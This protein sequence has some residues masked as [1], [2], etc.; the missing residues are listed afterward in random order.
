MNLDNFLVTVGIR[1]DPNAPL[2][3]LGLDLSRMRMTPY[4]HQ[5][6][7]VRAL[8]D[9]PWMAL[10]DEMGAGKTKQTLDAAQ[11]LWAAGVIDRVIIVTDA[12]VRDVWYDPE[13]GEIAKH[14]WKDLKANI[15][16]YHAKIRKWK[17]DTVGEPLDIPELKIV[18]A[19]YEFIRDKVRRQRLL[20]FC[21]KRTLLVL[22]ESSAI[23]TPSAKQTKVCFMLRRRCGRIVLLNGTPVADNPGDLYTQAQILHNS[24]LDCPTRQHFE[25]R[26]AKKGIKKGVPYPVIVDWVNLEDLQQRLAP[27]VLRR[28]KKD[29]LDLPEKMPPVE[30]EVTLRE[31]WPVYKEM[32]DQMVAWLK[33]PTKVATSTVAAVKV[34]RL[35]QIAN[36]FV[37]GVQTLEEDNDATNA[38]PIPA[39]IPRLFD[40]EPDL[41]TLPPLGHSEWAY[42]GS[43]K[44]DF[45]VVKLREWMAI[46]PDLKI[47]VYCRFKVE[48]KRILERLS[49]EGIPTVAMY[50]AQPREERTAALRALDPRSAPKGPLVGCLTFGTGSKGTNFTAAWITVYMSRGYS[51]EKWQQSMDRTHR[52]G[53]IRETQYFDLVAVGPKGQKTIDRT[54]IDSTNKKLDLSTFT[55]SAWLKEI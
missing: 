25:A 22:D 36:G 28:L 5:I 9:N 53:Q 4:Q 15:T 46:D 7:G 43:E 26:Y 1:R 40:D 50:G 3:P 37:G 35:S 32:R 27:Y 38:E 20:A 11:Y 21:T 13:F 30:L 8:I 19:N 49:F 48:L 39:W 31:S 44:L 42:V 24:I 6:E 33:D 45:L 17:I 34:M 12:S 16:E 51:L 23:R 55:T 10:F 14:G 47:L 18:I 52:P 54:I 29:C 2:N 41:S